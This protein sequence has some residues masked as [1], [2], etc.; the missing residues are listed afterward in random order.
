MRDAN[1]VSVE[2]KFIKKMKKLAKKFI[3]I[4]KNS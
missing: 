1:I 2:K 4:E 3:K